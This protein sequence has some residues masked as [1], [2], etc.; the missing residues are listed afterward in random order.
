MLV[1]CIEPIVPAVEGPDA[2]VGFFHADAF[3]SERSAQVRVLTVDEKATSAIDVEGLEVVR[4][5]RRRTYA[6]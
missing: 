5:F 6:G 2:V 3:T 4:V 1:R